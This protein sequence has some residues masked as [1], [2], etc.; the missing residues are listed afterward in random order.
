MIVN[1]QSRNAEVVFCVINT[2][3]FAKKNYMCG[4]IFNK[5]VYNSIIVKNNYIQKSTQAT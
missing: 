4:C 3:I 1:H 5:N 2:V